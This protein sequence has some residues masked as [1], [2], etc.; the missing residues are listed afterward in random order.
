MPDATSPDVREIFD[1]QKHH[2]SRLPSLKAGEGGKL[3]SYYR[4][5]PLG[6]SDTRTMLNMKWKFLVLGKSKIQAANFDE[7]NSKVSELSKFV[8]V[9]LSRH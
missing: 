1:A 5:K 6:E 8:L 9:L 3:I 2:M 4:Q 7:F